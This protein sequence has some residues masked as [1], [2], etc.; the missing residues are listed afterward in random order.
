MRYILKDFDS[1]MFN[2]FEIKLPDS[3]LELI[4]ELSHQVG[5]P[6]Y[7][8]TPV[9]AKREAP[10]TGG[11]LAH[12][13]SSGK[14]KRGKN[15]E[16]S[17]E[18]WEAIRNFQATKM[19]EKTG[20]DASIDVIRSHLNKITDKNYTDYRNKIIESVGQII[21]NYNQEDVMRV[22]SIIFEIASTNRFYSKMYADLY[23][24]LIKQFSCMQTVLETNFNSY[25]ELF[26]KIEYHDPNTDYDNFCKMNKTNEKRKSLSSFFVNL[27]TKEIITPLHIVKLLKNLLEQ[28]YTFIK[29]ENKKNE[30]DELT[31]NIGLLYSSEL[32]S[33]DDYDDITI[34]DMNIVETIQF[35]SECKSKDYASL[36]S[37]SVFKYMDIVE[38]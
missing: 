28:V 33:E 6:N 8:K 24:D 37:K 19:E 27:C 15:S 21:E 29:Q 30:V 18:D 35:L 11:D 34:D 5:S 12:H 20:I 31:E 2:G 36:T 7:V 38:Q 13:S 14:K 9:F 25:L 23:S 16:M 22:G 32:F 4:S 10:K 1:I 26:D 3:T 17:S